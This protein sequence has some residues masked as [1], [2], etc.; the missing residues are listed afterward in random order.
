MKNTSLIGT[1]QTHLSAKF[2]SLIQ[3]NQY[4]KLRELFIGLFLGAELVWR[5]HLMKIRKCDSLFIVFLLQPQY[6]FTA[7]L[8]VP[9]SWVTALNED[10][11]NNETFVYF[12][13]ESTLKKKQKHRKYLKVTI[14]RRACTNHQ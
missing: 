5:R 14:R 7:L 11:K 3:S 4:G 2:L 10:E 9:K 8:N 13:S 12:L 1:L 6:P